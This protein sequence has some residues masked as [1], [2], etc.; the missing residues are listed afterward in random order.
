MVRMHD[1]ESW[2]V[3]CV[4]GCRSCIKR[5]IGMRS[6][7]ESV[8]RYKKA[9]TAGFEPARAKPNRFLVCLLNHS[10]K[11]SLI[12]FSPSPLDCYNQ[13]LNPPSQSSCTILLWYSRTPFLFLLWYE[14]WICK[15]IC[16]LSSS[17]LYP[18]T[19][20]YLSCSVPYELLYSGYVQLLVPK[21]ILVDVFLELL[22]YVAD[23]VLVRI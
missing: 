23:H 17:S 11:L 12:V 15:L 20:S 18:W 1:S 21:W 13:Q 16:S 2:N 10:D 4:L 14:W 5:V 6:I 3:G 9:T 22:L 19:W 7:G 8:T